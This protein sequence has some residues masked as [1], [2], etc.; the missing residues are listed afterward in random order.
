[1][2]QLHNA[3]FYVALVRH[4]KQLDSLDH[5]LEDPGLKPS[6]II[7][8]I[9]VL[10]LDIPVCA[11]GVWRGEDSS[12]LEAFEKRNEV[13]IPSCRRL[14]TKLRTSHV[15]QTHFGSWMDSLYNDLG[16]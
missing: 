16:S 1:M 6:F 10:I 14:Y 7:T 12:L 2:S 11:S 3:Q 15:L 5:A 13:G 8:I 4:R 9:P